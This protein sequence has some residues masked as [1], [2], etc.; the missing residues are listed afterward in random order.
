MSNY[1]YNCGAEC[2]G[3]KMVEIRKGSY[4][5]FCPHCFNKPIAELRE[6]AKHNR[7][8]TKGLNSN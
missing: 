1:C 3:K 6:N 4:H 2:K 8:K 7:L 5:V